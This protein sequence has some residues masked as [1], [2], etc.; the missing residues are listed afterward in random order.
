MVPSVVSL[1]EI[2]LPWGWRGHV[3][4]EGARLPARH[5]SAVLAR[6]DRPQDGRH[7]LR[8][9]LPGALYDRKSNSKLTIQPA[10]KALLLSPFAFSSLLKMELLKLK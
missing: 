1:L 4:V 7:R 5:R 6:L 3:G 9:S 8:E 2:I 10:K